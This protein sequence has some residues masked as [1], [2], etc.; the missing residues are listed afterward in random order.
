MP[1]VHVQ[2]SDVQVSNTFWLECLVEALDDELAILGH[3]E[4]KKSVFAHELLSC[5][6]SLRLDCTCLEARGSL[7]FMSSAADTTESRLCVVLR[8]S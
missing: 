4:Q 8:G 1:C 3:C 7:A 2:L 6:K 5:C